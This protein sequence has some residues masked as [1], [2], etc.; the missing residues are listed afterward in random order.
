V[1]PLVASHLEWVRPTS[2]NKMFNAQIAYRNFGDQWSEHR[3]VAQSGSDKRHNEEV[4][5]HL[6]TEV[7]LTSWQLAASSRRITAFGSVLPLAPVRQALVSYRWADGLR[8]LQHEIEF[9]DGRHGDPEID[10]WVVILPQ[11]TRTTTEREWSVAERVLSVHR[12]G[13]WNG[14]PPLVNAYAGPDDRALAEM[15]TGKREAG[16]T[17]ADLDTLTRPRRGVILIYPLPHEPPAERSWVPT[18]GFSLLFPSNSIP[19]QIGFTVARSA[20]A[21]EPVVDATA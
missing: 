9:L 17:T 19:R 14:T 20:L 21:G 2:R 8:D 1:P 7:G 11:L 3:R 4:F 16:R 18:I 5:R 10:D 13:Y 15:I 6:L 12:R